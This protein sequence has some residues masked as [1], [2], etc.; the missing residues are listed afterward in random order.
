MLRFDFRNS[1][2][3]RQC[4]D[5][6]KYVVKRSVTELFQRELR[7]DSGFLSYVVSVVPLQQSQTCDFAPLAAVKLVIIP[8]KRKELSSTS[9]I[10]GFQDKIR[11]DLVSRC[12][13]GSVY[14]RPG[15]DC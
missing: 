8:R 1:G 11:V 14:C 4:Y 7:V 2:A 15:N 10:A 12:G 6:L 13:H 5:S 9:R 3:L